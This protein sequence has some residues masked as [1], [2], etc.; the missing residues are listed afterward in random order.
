MENLISE[1]R[2]RNA[3]NLYY[4]KHRLKLDMFI[5]RRLSSGEANVPH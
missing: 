3:H 4:V 5:W 2:S 1:E